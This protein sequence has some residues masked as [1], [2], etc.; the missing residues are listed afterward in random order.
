MPSRSVLGCFRWALGLCVLLGRGDAARPAE[1]DGDLRE[2]VESYEADREDVLR[3]YDVPDSPLR[4]P[5]LEQFY[6][7]WDDKLAK[8]PF[9]E[10]DQPA[11][12][13]YI[14][15]ANHIKREE[16]Q[17]KLDGEA[18]RAIEPLAP[19]LAAIAEL[20]TARRKYEFVEGQAAAGRLAELSARVTA[21]KS[22]L[23][24]R[25]AKSGSGERP[26]RTDGRRAANAVNAASR[27]LRRWYEFYH[28]YDPVVSWWIE[29]P[30]KKLDAA[31]GRLRQI[32][33]AEGRGPQR[34]RQID[35]LGQPDRPCRTR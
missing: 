10:L 5:R 1:H 2:V 8:I 14:L 17:L 3:E 4:G 23:E 28:G 21:A 27:T 18:Q 15:L 7:E 29:A 20:E 33:A 35:R 12:I 25:L 34:R 9:D 31:P 6:R 13:D 26:K 22:D 19:F 30:Y 11:K 32:P 16:R 24:K